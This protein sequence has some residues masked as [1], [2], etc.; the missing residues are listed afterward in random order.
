M[1]LGRIERGRRG[2]GTALLATAAAVVAGLLAAPAGASAEGH[3]NVMTRNLYLG[4]DLTAAVHSTSIQQLVD[5]AGGIFHEIDNNDFR[6][7][8]RGLAGEIR[9][10]R[11]DLVGLQE[12]TL[13]RTEPCTV[14]PLP[15]KATHVRYDYLKLLLDQLN[16]GAKRY[17]TV[18]VQDEFDFEIWVNTDG[19]ES[20][21]APGC[22]FGSEINARLTLRDAILAR[23]GTVQTSNAAGGQFDTLLQVRP[24][25]VPVNITRGWTQADAKVPGA[26][27]FRFVNTH[28]E[29]F[30]NQETGNHTNKGTDVNRGQVRQAQARQLVGSGGAATGPLPVILLGDL[31]SDKQTEVHPPGDSLAYKVFLNHGFFERSTTNPLGCC[32]KAHVLTP[33]SSGQLSNLTHKVDHV[34]TNV[35]SKV[36]L[37]AAAVTGRT[38]HNNFWDSDHMGL[39]SALSLDFP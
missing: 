23:I 3:L 5:A 25:G 37:E 16:K 19:N 22:P 15:P 35:P 20:T 24:G 1:E 11:P 12:T 17:R 4:A 32:I 29:S 36:E 30:D 8:A 9:N 39:Y 6:V 14:T 13:V 2:R 28:L 31:N 27:T 7:R 33:A 38:P 10:K 18:V 26:G 21:S 34:I